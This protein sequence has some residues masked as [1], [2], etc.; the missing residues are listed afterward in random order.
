MQSAEV[1]ILPPLYATLELSLMQ[2]FKKKKSNAL[3]LFWNHG[4][5]SF[6]PLIFLTQIPF[7]WKSPS[8]SR[9]VVGSGLCWCPCLGQKHT[10][11]LSQVGKRLAKIYGK[12]QISWESWMWFV[13]FLTAWRVVFL[14]LDVGKICNDKIHVSIQ[15]RPKVSKQTCGTNWDVN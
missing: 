11:E 15:K 3:T 6:P 7:L 2:H 12:I 14:T 8:S 9:L 4:Y 13:C 5:H 10:V 1:A